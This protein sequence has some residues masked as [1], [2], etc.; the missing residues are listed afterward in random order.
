V[1]FF[2]EQETIQHLVFDRPMARLMWEII[3]FTFGATKPV[4]AEN[5]FGPWLRSFSIKPRNLV[6]I[7]TAA[8]CLTLWIT[9]NDLVFQKS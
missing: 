1:L 6:L 8:F 2:M 3:C 5:H 7:G 9:R 4:D